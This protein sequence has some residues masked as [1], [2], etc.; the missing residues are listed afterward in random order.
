MMNRNFYFCVILVICSCTGCNPELDNEFQAIVSCTNIVAPNRIGFQDI[1][2]QYE[3]IRLETNDNCLLGDIQKLVVFDGC[4]YILSNNFFCF[5]GDG[6]FVYNISNRGN[7][8]GE[9]VRINDFTINEGKIYLYDNPGGKMLVCEPKTGKY[10]EELKIVHSAHEIELNGNSIYYNRL[11]IYNDKVKNSNMMIVHQMN[12]PQKVTSYFS[13]ELYLGKI[14]NQLIKSNNN[15]FW[16]DPYACNIYKMSDN[17][18][19]SYI[20]LDFGDKNVLPQDIMS[21]KIKQPGQLRKGNKAWSLQDYY[22]TN[23]LL[24]ARLFIGNDICRV[25]ANKKTTKSIVIKG[26]TTDFYRPYEL[27]ENIVASDSLA[28]YGVLPATVID[29]IRETTPDVVSGIPAYY[30]NVKDVFQNLN[31]EDNPVILK[32]VFNKKNC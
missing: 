28:F 12:S 4:F 18:V 16:L 14:Q 7:G 29:R 1:V 6:E 13:S 23:E 32:Y 22:E 11:S 15:I 10:I 24:T 31:K 2:N 26:F 17:N 30:K 20:D 19:I 27:L 9:F 25:V 21:G 3:M 8:P 5:N